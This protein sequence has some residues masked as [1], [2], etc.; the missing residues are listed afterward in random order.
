MHSPRRSRLVHYLCPFFV[1]FSPLVPLLDSWLRSL[2]SPSISTQFSPVSFCLELSSLLLLHPTQL[3]LS[4]F[5]ENFI[6]LALQ[7]HLPFYNHPIHLNSQ[8]IYSH[9]AP[10][11]YSTWEL[12]LENVSQFSDEHFS[13][14]WL[15]FS[16]QASQRRSNRPPYFSSEQCVSSS[17]GLSCK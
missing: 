1:F 16:F 10:V 17:S 13:K 4:F 6:A 5:T 11:W 2:F 7:S 12:F 14:L 15:S 3:H 8:L 9:Y